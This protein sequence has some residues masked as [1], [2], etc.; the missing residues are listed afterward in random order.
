M[1]GDEAASVTVGLMPVRRH[2]APDIHENL[3][4]SCWL[5]SDSEGCLKIPRKRPVSRISRGSV[6]IAIEALMQSARAVTRD[7][8]S[9][10]YHGQ[11]EST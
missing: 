4:T 5:S 1:P 6:T 11:P 9:A 2:E 3:V 7:G 8:T 10:G